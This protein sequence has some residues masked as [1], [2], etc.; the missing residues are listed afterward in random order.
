MIQPLVFSV[1]A[2]VLDID[3]SLLS[4]T[5]T[6]SDFYQWDSLANM[7]IWIEINSRIGPLSFDD[8]I[9]CSCLGDLIS[10]IDSSGVSE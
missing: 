1:I 4:N 3:A 10:A 2:S 8:Y 5:S 7:S 6:P 9:S